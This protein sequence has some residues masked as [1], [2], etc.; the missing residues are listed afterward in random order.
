MASSPEQDASEELMAR[1]GA[2]LLFAHANGFCKETWDPVIRRLKQSP[3]LQQ[4]VEEYVTYDQ[5]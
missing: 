4:A 5:P 1:S 2:T 3:M